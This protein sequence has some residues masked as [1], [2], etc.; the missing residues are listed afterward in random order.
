[1]DEAALEPVVLDSIHDADRAEWDR[2]AGGA[3]FVAWDWLAA[4]EDS[5][6]ASPALDWQPAHVVLRSGDRAVGA[7]PL[8]VRSGTD[9]EFIWEVP[10]RR[11]WRRLGHPT[12][13]RAVVTVP[14]TPVAGP[15]LL[16]GD[17]PGADAR[18]LLL[19]RVL[20][21]LAVERGWAS[22]SVQ[23]C[24]PQ[25]A[26]VLASAGLATRSTWQYHWQ[27]RGYSSFEDH[28]AAMRSRRRNKV[29]REVRELERQGIEVAIRPGDRA[30][31]Q[32]MAHLYAATS[33]RHHVVP[34]PLSADFFSALGERFGDS[35]RFGVASRD[36]DVIAMTLNLLYG[37]TLYGR[38][39]GYAGGDLPFLHF[40]VAYNRAVA[41]CIEQGIRR[42]EPGHG[43]EFKRRR[44]FDPVLMCS[45]HWLPDPRFQQAVARWAEDE[46]EWVHQRV[47]GLDH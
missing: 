19:A 40:N 22:L 3:P 6:D 44:G 14:W 46:S 29:R 11:A 32:R 25:E 37:D 7:C 34:A 24:W 4:L 13:P 41:W 10:I 39:W 5:G 38:F 2:L 28:L 43:G 33:A 45:A 9:G 8:Y 1:M 17:E 15:R 27:N 35:I 23:F 31:F 18:R 42:L 21:S 20:Q 12:A 26:E 16:V 36:G 47:S 30:D